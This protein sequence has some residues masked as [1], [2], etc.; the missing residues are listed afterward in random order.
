MLEERVQGLEREMV[1]LK[2]RLARVER[3]QGVEVEVRQAPRPARVK[4][5]EQV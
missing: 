4:G 1:G 2:E 5:A 3:E